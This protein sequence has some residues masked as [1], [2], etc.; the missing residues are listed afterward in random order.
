MR[1]GEVCDLAADAVVLI[2]DGHWLR[3]PIG[4]LRNDRY[5]PLHPDLVVLLTGWTA[6]NLDHI[7]RHQRL[8]ADHRGSLDR[9]ALARIVRPRRTPSRR[10]HV[11]PHQLRHT[12]ATQAINRGMRLEAIAALLGH[13]SMDMTLT[14]ARIADRVVADEYAASTPRS[15]RSTAKHRQLPADS[16]PPAWPNSAARPTPACSATGSAPAPSS[17]TAGSNQ[18]A[19]PAATSAPASSSSPSC[20]ANATTPETTASPTAQRSSHAYSTASKNRLDT[21]T[22]ITTV[23]SATPVADTTAHSNGRQSTTPSRLDQ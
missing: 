17:S 20:S 15:T 16:R 11:H 23:R 2:G 10:R 4:K 5:V 13:R 7:R 18:P 14:Y 8:V 6:D 22:R 9:H 19:K 12:L 3:V 1:A 21:I